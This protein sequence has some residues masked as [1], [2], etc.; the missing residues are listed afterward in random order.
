MKFREESYTLLKK[1]PAKLLETQE[2]QQVMQKVVQK[3]LDKGH[4]SG[5]SLE[6]VMMSIKEHLLCG[7]LE[8][9]RQEFQSR[10]SIQIK[11]FER[12]V[13][14]LCKELIDS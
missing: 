2:Y 12:L 8:Q 11:Y 4:F 14:L 6:E 10:F 7:K 13:F 9:M 3:F 1:D 5:Q